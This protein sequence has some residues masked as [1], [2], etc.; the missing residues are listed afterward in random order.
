MRLGVARQHREVLVL[1]EPVAKLLRLAHPA[2]AKPRPQRLD[3]LHLVAVHHHALAE[4]VQVIDAGGAPVLGNRV[5]GALV[6]LAQSLGHVGECQIV[7]RP[8]LDPRLGAIHRAEIRERIAVVRLAVSAWARRSSSLCADGLPGLRRQPV[9]RRMLL[10][11]GERVERG[12]GVA[13]AGQHP[14]EVARFGPPAAVV[15]RQMRL[16]QPQ[17]RAP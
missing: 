5:A 3:Q 15:G 6:M 4:I 14:R 12:L 16:D 1:A 11:V 17:K 7:D 9:R 13:G 8:A 10:G 2:S